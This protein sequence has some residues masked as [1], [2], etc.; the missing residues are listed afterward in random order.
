MSVLP[1]TMKK[2]PYDALKDFAPISLIA[3]NYLALVVHPSTPFKN[4]GDFVEISQE[5]SRQGGI[6]E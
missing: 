5:Q 6:C 1:H 4:V 3:T 2:I